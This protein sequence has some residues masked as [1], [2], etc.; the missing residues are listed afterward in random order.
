MDARAATILLLVLLIFQANPSS[1][2][3]SCIITGARMLMCMQPTC[4]CGCEL[5]AAVHHAQLKDTWCE[6]F[7]RGFCRCKLCNNS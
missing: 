3:E 2:E 5:D 7:F 4:F 1:A 6:G